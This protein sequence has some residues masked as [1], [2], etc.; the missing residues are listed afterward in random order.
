VYE[1]IDD[2]LIY[3]SGLVEDKVRGEKHVKAGFEDRVSF[4]KVHLLAS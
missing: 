2:V 1:G 3:S 4:L